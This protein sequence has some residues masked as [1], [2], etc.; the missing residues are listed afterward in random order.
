MIDSVQNFLDLT[1][2]AQS[3]LDDFALQSQ[4]FAIEQL[5]PHPDINIGCDMRLKGLRCDHGQNRLLNEKEL[6]TGNGA[7]ATL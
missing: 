1:E 2:F 6:A 3:F 7:K 4:T 5:L